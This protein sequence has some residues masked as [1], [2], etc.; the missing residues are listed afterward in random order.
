V[1]VP[2]LA[3]GRLITTPGY[4]TPTGL[5]LDLRGELPVIPKVLDKKVAEA[6]K[7]R[8][9]KPF[10]G[11]LDNGATTKTESLRQRSQP[12]CGHPCPPRRPSSSTATT[13]PW[14]RASWRVS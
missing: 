7:R 2:L 4:H 10:R 6:A 11:Y 5:I 8:L 3:D 12:S 13:R 1:H 14:A 9:L